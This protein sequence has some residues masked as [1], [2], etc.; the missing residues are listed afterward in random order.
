MLD[1]KAM[2]LSKRSTFYGEMAV[3]VHK[4]GE[5]L[6]VDD[7]QHQHLN[8]CVYDGDYNRDHKEGIC[9]IATYLGTQ[10]LTAA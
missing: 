6:L 4:R 3:M 7:D 2:I 8:V 1:V 9:S 5:W 10:S